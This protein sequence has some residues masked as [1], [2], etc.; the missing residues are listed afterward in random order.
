[1]K[2]AFVFAAA[3]MSTGCVTGA[4]YDQDRAYAKCDKIK[5]VTVRDRCIAEAIKDSERA[6]QDQARKMEQDR[7]EAEDRELDRVIA[8]AGNHE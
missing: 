8:G 1:M 5:T 3:L 2:Y 7:L 6:R 4:E